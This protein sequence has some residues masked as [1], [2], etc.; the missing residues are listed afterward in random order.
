[1]APV[2]SVDHRPVW[3]EVDVSAIAANVRAFAAVT[4]GAGV[5][6]VVKADGYGHGAVPVARAALEAGATHLGVALV[7]E[8]VELRA[9]GIDAPVIVLSEPVPSAADAVVQH[10]LTPVVYTAAGIEALAKAVAA[11]NAPPLGVHVKIDT[12]MHRV[13]CTP[14]HAP[15]LARHVLAHRELRL[16]GTC[17]HFAVADEPGN[18]YTGEQVVRFRAALRAM[19]AAGAEPGTVHL[20]NTAGVLTAPEAHGDLVRIGI[21]LYGIAP[22]PELAEAIALRPAMSVKARVTYV[23]R[24]P[25]GARIS[26]GLRYETRRAT[27]L[28]TV[29]IGY[30]DGVPRSLGHRGGRALVRGVARPIAGTVTM[31]QLVLDVG[32]DDVEAGDEVV[33]IGTQGDATVT[34]ADWAELTGTIPYEIVCG[35]GP[36]VPRT[37]R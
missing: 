18:P 16:A 31:D 32:D 5:V 3:A 2:D 15:E 1:M 12:G 30:A 22:S 25:A 34:A 9:E 29:P 21:G 19:R 36:R 13:G 10:G 23:K 11:G 27:T 17:T 37:Y 14:E 24:V 7:E 33:L 26:Y 35:I 4:N 28:A 20:C 8:G 6:A